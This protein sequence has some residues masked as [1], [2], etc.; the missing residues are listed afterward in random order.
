MAVAA[1]EGPHFIGEA[2]E[3]GRDGAKFYRAFQGTKIK[4][5]IGDTVRISGR[6]V[7]SIGIIIALWEIAKRG[8]RR[9]QRLAEILLFD[10]LSAKQNRPVCY[11]ASRY[12]IS[13]LTNLA[14][15]IYHPG[16]VS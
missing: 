6:V 12:R 2:L 15:A 8:R 7:T 10:S 3:D 14:R 5:E 16:I 1:D 4:A 9:Q 13:L 11:K